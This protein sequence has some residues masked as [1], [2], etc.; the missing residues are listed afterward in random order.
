MNEQLHAT[1][2]EIAKRILGVESLDGRGSDHLDFKEQSFWAIRNAMIEAYVAGTKDAKVGAAVVPLQAR[3]LT[4]RD[5]AGS[6]VYTGRNPDMARK[7]TLMAQWGNFAWVLWDDSLGD[8]VPPP[9]PESIHTSHLWVA[10]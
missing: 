1:L 5:P 9:T 7:G 3:K 10:G 8:I 4:P 6:V 2:S